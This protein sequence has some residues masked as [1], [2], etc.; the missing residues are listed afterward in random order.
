MVEVITLERPEALNALSDAMVQEVAGAFREVAADN[1][2][3]VVLLAASGPKAFCV[4]ADLKERA[5]FS[6]DDYYENRA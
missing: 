5:G 3:W 1:D 2:A 4:G 6:L